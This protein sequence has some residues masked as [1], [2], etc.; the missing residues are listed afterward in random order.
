MKDIPFS[1]QINIDVE[2]YNWHGLFHNGLS[3]E[4]VDL[5][6]NSLNKYFDQQKLIDLGYDMKNPEPNQFWLEQKKNY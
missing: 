6:R 1:H 5:I 3:D 4:E 2:V